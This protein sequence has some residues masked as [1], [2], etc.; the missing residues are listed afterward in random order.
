MSGDPK[1]RAWEA[2]DAFI[3]EIISRYEILF[4]WPASFVT[5]MIVIMNQGKSST[6]SYGQSC[7]LWGSDDRAND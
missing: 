7:S 6:K 3:F 4:V 5:P 2:I 1:E